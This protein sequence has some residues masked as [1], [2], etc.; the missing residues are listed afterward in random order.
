TISFGE[1]LLEQ[2]TAQFDK[3]PAILC[4][5][6]EMSTLRINFLSPSD[7]T[8]TGLDA[9]GGVVYARETVAFDALLNELL[10]ATDQ[11]LRVA[12]DHI[13]GEPGDDLPHV[14]KS[15]RELIDRWRRTTERLRQSRGRER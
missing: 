9:D 10:S 15:N 4:D 14:F 13:L 3:R 12:D 7:V 2:L 6:T 8:I 5:L 11:F 1:Q